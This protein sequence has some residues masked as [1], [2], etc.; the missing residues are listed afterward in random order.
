MNSLQQL[1]SSTAENAGKNITRQLLAAS[2][3]L[4]A[5]C[6]LCDFS[7][8]CNNEHLAPDLVTIKRGSYIFRHGDPSN[9]LYRVRKG[10][11]KLSRFRI[12][13]EEQ[14]LGFYFKDESFGFDSL[15]NQRRKDEAIALEDCTL[16]RYSLQAPYKTANQQTLE[17]ILGLQNKNTSKFQEHII[18]INT[19]NAGTRLA[20]FLLD[21]AT[22]THIK[23]SNS[24]VFP[25]PMSRYDIASYLGLTQETV[26]RRLS[27]LERNHI[28]SMEN[29]RKSVRIL[30]LEH[31][32]QLAY[33]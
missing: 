19:S 21:V 4:N 9:H 29:N 3:R 22:H 8:S 13:G 16:C 33:F 27:Q 2:Q 15:T 24:I 11:V 5:D 31:L 18:L 30:N 10:S 7:D 6:Q 28:I 20:A 14:V 25:L 32:Q 17:N 26:S 23:Q 12:S 1:N